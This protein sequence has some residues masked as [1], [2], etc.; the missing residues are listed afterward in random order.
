MVCTTAAP[1]ENPDD[2]DA[3]APNA[4]AD[5]LLK[6]NKPPADG[7]TAV[8]AVDV[9]VLGA[10]TNGLPVVEAVGAVP[11]LLIGP[12]LNRPALVVV[13]AASE[14]PLPDIFIVVVTGFV[15]KQLKN[16]AEGKGLLVILV[17]GIIVVALGAVGIG[18]GPKSKRPVGAEEL[19]A[20][21]IL[22]AV[23]GDSNEAENQRR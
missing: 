6:L 19:T 4:G 10:K 11:E 23:G 7:K 17:V 12:K 13:G 9:V 8:V 2:V 15:P 22:F 1:K 3:L 14:A 18:F 20:V 5:P 16:P 21:A